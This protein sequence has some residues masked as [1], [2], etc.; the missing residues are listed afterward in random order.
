MASRSEIE[1]AKLKMLEARRV[2]EEYE[3]RKNAKNN[4]VHAIL[5][6]AFER[7]C[8]KYLKLSEKES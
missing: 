8:S 4:K 3:A 5:R 1:D 7:A 2:L 6:S